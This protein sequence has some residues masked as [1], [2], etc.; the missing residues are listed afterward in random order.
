M[1]LALPV[2]RQLESLR[3][4]YLFAGVSSTCE[5]SLPGS[6]MPVAHA[7][8]VYAGIVVGNLLRIGEAIR[9]SG[10][11]D[12]LDGLISPANCLRHLTPKLRTTPNL[13]E[14]LRP[15]EVLTNFIER[16][17]M[18]ILENSDQSFLSSS[19]LASARGATPLY[20]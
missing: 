5:A 3:A 2:G 4:R 15:N 17:R 9:T 16:W 8:G 6:T 20:R 19:L 18:D 10:A 14:D 7:G 11:G 1:L 12:V 13:I